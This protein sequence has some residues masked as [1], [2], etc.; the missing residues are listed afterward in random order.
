L[1]HTLLAW[2]HITRGMA[3]VEADEEKIKA[4]LDSHWEV[5][6]EGA[7][8]ILRAAGRNDAYESLK[9]RTRG[10]VVDE[11]S[12][13][14]WVETLDIDEETRARL[15]SLSPESYI[16]LAAQLADQVLRDSIFDDRKAE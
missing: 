4:E 1:G 15:Q 12:Y 9:S 6:G 16:G 14:R 10:Q 7:Q 2:N 8:T 11:S 3:R 5:V 13:R